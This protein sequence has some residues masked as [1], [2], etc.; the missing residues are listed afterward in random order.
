MPGAFSAAFRVLRLLGG[1]L[2]FL[3]LAQ[4]VIPAASASPAA[5]DDEVTDPFLTRLLGEI[6]VRRKAAG[7]PQLSYVPRRANDALGRFLGEIAPSLGWPGPCG[8]LT[9]DGGSSW[10]YMQARGAFGAEARGEV[11]A[12]PGPEP[13]WTPDR[14]ADI[15]WESPIHHAIL[16][17]DSGANAV[18]CNAV[19]G[20]KKSRSAPAMAVLCVTFHE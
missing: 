20:S 15:W 16:Y 17:A 5:R 7:T 12:C 13:Y 4:L 8:H 19:G 9:V 11:L 18:A 3:V 10:D 6:N 1:L 14:A 2:V